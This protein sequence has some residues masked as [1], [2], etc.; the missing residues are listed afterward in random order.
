MIDDDGRLQYYE[1]KQ[2]LQDSMTCLQLLIFLHMREGHF[3]VRRLYP[4]TS[5]AKL[6]ILLIDLE[7]ESRKSTADDEYFIFRRISHAYY[8]FKPW[9]GIY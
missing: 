4:G 3:R 6:H 2:Y 9:K 7:W 5:Y 1:I 8:L